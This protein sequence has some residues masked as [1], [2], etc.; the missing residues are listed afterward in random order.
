[1]SKINYS[2]R[3]G[4]TLIETIIAIIISSIIVLS[5]SGYLQSIVR[6]FHINKMQIDL[7][8]SIKRSMGLITYLLR[9]AY[10]DS[11]TITHL[12]GEPPYSRIIFTNPQGQFS[13][14]QQGTKLLF[15]N[16]TAGTTQELTNCLTRISFLYLDTRDEDIISVSLCCERRA[17]QKIFATSVEKIKL[18]N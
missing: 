2:N 7:Q 13:F 14:S 5:L 3:N 16:L 12:P 4:I 17:P 10:N 6:F 15:S 9:S 8:N 11:I 18:M 1:M